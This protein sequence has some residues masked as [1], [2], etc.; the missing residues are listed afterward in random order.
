MNFGEAS[1]F[2][3]QSRTI[4]RGLSSLSRILSTASGDGCGKEEEED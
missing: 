1:P 2:M 3:E 4:S